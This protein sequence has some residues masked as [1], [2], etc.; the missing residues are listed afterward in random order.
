MF[1]FDAATTTQ[2][3]TKRYINNG[4]ACTHHHHLFWVFNKRSIVANKWFGVCRCRCRCRWWWWWWWCSCSMLIFVRLLNYCIVWAVLWTHTHRLT[5]THTCK[6]NAD[7]AWERQTTQKNDSHSYLIIKSTHTHITHENKI[8]QND[9]FLDKLFGIGEMNEKT[10]LKKR[11]NK[12]T[13]ERN[14]P[15][16]AVCL[17]VCSFLIDAMHIRKWVAPILES[18]CFILFSFR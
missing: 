7:A 17:F 11:A 6:H 14:S 9:I 3:A 13:N 5:Q 4:T 16:I 15:Q 12:R 1:F 2:S 18:A 10:V 8:I